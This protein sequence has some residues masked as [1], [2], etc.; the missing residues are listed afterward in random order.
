MTY[1]EKVEYVRRLKEKKIEEDESCS[2]PRYSN[3]GSGSQLK[4]E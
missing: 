2:Y 4:V 1:E 3:I